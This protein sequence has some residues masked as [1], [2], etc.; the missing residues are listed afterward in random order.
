MNCR[1]DPHSTLSDSE[2]A[3]FSDE[4]TS[5]ATTDDPTAASHYLLPRFSVKVTDG[6]TIISAVC[7]AG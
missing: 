5:K 7:A 6:V 2:D 1:G 3:S 4:P